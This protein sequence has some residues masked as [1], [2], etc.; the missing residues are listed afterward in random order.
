MEGDQSTCEADQT[1]EASAGHMQEQE[2]GR[3]GAQVS[4]GPPLMPKVSSQ[5]DVA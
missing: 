5:A 2:A 3:Q 4:A 1:A